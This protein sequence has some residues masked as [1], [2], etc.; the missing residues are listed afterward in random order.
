MAQL[1]GKPPTKK[2]NDTGQKGGLLANVLGTEQSNKELVQA[3]YQTNDKN[4]K[5]VKGHS[6]SGVDVDNLRMSGGDN[7]EKQ[8]AK[9]MFDFSM[10]DSTK[11][12]L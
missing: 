1:I 4:S 12:L 11:K 5:S 7:I 3:A 9:G 2:N 8:A 6:V 10:D